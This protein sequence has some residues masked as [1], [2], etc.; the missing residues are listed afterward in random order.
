M[1]WEL[2]WV[3]WSNVETEH[4]GS[5]RFRFVRASKRIQLVRCRGF[6]F[7]G[8]HPVRSHCDC[9][10]KQQL[11][12]AMVEQDH[13]EKPRG[14]NAPLYIHNSAAPQYEY[15]FVFTERD[16]DVAELGDDQVITRFMD[17]VAASPRVGAAWRW[18]ARLWALIARN[19]GLF[20]PFSPAMVLPNGL[21]FVTMLSHLPVALL[22]QF[23]F[24]SE[25]AFVP[26][27]FALRP[28]AAILMLKLIVGMIAVL[29]NATHSVSGG[30]VRDRL[31]VFRVVR[32]A[33]HVSEEM[34]RVMPGR[35]TVGRG[36]TV[37]TNGNAPNQ[38]FGNGPLLESEATS[39]SLRKLLKKAYKLLKTTAKTARQ[40]IPAPVKQFSKRVMLTLQV[41]MLACGP[42]FRRLHSR[43]KQI[44]NYSLF[45]SNKRQVARSNAFI[46]EDDWRARLPPDEAVDPEQAVVCLGVK[47]HRL[48]AA[49][50]YVV[51]KNQYESKMVQV[52]VEPGFPGLYA[53]SA[54]D[55]ESGGRGSADSPSRGLD[56]RGGKLEPSDAVAN[57]IAEA[58]A[59]DPG[60]TAAQPLAGKRSA[61]SAHAHAS[62]N[63]SGGMN[64]AGNVDLHLKQFEFYHQASLDVREMLRRRA[65]ASTWLGQVC[66]FYAQH[67]RIKQLPQRGAS[68]NQ[69][70]RRRPPGAND[71]FKEM[72]WFWL[73]LRWL[74]LRGRMLL[75]F[76]YAVRSF[77]AALAFLDCTQCCRRREKNNGLNSSHLSSPMGKSSLFGSKVYPRSLRPNAIRPLGGVEEIG[78][79]AGAALNSERVNVEC[80]TANSIRV[81][82]HRPFADYSRSHK[83][84]SRTQAGVAAGGNRTRIV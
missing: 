7:F 8:Q 47:N 71:V 23:W 20:H 45:T 33:D 59:M 32:V 76:V 14:S 74:T 4:Y 42:L 81:A 37:A 61:S 38:D 57:R 5:K 1:A 28:A 41:L 46:R 68:H 69:K 56:R 70:Q 29:T 75:Q 62:S 54:A 84:L 18:A 21:V 30:S 35:A 52:C 79:G 13:R 24:L 60:A 17:V 39:F 73:R 66:L 64:D 11:Q 63:L 50:H 67:E 43:L 16:F 9:E 22:K 72:L 78:S 48:V 36:R 2:E 40:R 25:L 49:E 15:R 53:S 31:A 80:D 82:W 34:R 77:L 10:L 51:L 83:R 58:L 26:V 19:R 44:S 6:A 65:L 27:G 3:V 55:G 12:L